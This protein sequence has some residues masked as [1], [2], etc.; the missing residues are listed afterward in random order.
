MK[1]FRLCLFVLLVGI[2]T[3]PFSQAQWTVYD[4][5]VHRQQILSTAQEI[6]KFVEVINNQMSQLEQLS[7]QVSTLHHY[8]ELFGDPAAITPEAVPSL[9]EELKKTEIGRTLGE[10]QATADATQAMLERGA[11][12]YSAVGEL[13][14]TP[15]GTPIR[16][17]LEPYRPIAAVQQAAANFINVTKEIAVRRVELKN[18][19]AKTLQELRAATTDAE[20]QKLSGVLVGLGVALDNAGQEMAQATASAVIQDI[21]NRADAQR[22][23]EALKEQQQAEFQ[24]AITRYGQV[25]PLLNQVARFPTR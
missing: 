23:V 2:G 16:R 4:P 11:G 17:R 22:Q 18:E 3:G 15:G 19:F 10:L 6:A 21:A 8:V 20:V 12:L 9:T 7:E 24:E 25:F 5:T 14:T 1:H 13:F